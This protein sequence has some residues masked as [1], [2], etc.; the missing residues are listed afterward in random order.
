MHF[1]SPTTFHQLAFAVSREC[2]WSAQMTPVGDRDE[3]DVHARAQ[4]ELL[5]AMAR[6]D[7]SALGRIYDLLSKPL[8]SLAYR[9]LNDHPEAQDVVHDVFL[10]LWKSAKTYDADRGSVFAWAAT[11][12]RNRSIDRVR[13]RKRRAE[14]L[15]ESAADIHGASPSAWGA[16]SV[17][18]KENSGAVRA[19]LTQLPPEQQA[20]LELA[21]FG[22]LTQVEISTRLNEPLGTVKA[23]IR[24]GLL[25]LRATL[26]PR[27]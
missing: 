15:A 4:A 5:H 14:I 9:V 24:R 12:T 18:S 8:Y 27:L 6:G 25:K 21:Y 17:S 26:P 3:R 16:D 10:Q 7:K 20:A 19:A 13:R 11:L 23:R 22:G 1:A 2:C